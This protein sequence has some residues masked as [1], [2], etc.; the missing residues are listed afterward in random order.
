MDELNR[1]NSVWRNP[2]LRWPSTPTHLKSR[3]KSDWNSPRRKNKFN[4]SYTLPMI[5]FH[6]KFIGLSLCEAN[7]LFDKE[8]IKHWQTF[9]TGRTIWHIFRNFHPSTGVEM[10]NY[11]HEHG[12]FRWSGVE[13]I[14][15]IYLPVFG[16]AVIT[17]EDW[18]WCFPGCGWSFADDATDSTTWNDD[19][20]WTIRHC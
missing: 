12:L 13:I 14:F 11:K 18:A 16:W 8:L 7:S 5:I 10:K 15:S 9:Q 19:F 6:D 1:N 20:F 4:G 3:A 17:W 2:C